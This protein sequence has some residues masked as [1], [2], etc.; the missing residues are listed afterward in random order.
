MHAIMRI[1]KASEKSF[2]R[3]FDG[4]RVNRVRGTR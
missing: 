4:F 3:F 2:L 1:T